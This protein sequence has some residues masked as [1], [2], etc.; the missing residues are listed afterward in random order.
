MDPG[1]LGT[2]QSPHNHPPKDSRQGCSGHSLA[3]ST[4]APHPATA[5]GAWRGAIMPCLLLTLA[6]I[7]APSAA[8]SGCAT[9]QMLFNGQVVPSWIVCDRATML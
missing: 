9:G 5:R 1:G 3:V 7:R 6:V 2:S 4:V 8:K